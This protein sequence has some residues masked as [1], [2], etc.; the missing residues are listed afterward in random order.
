MLRNG[1][2]RDEEHLRDFNRKIVALGEKLG[3]PV[4]A[5][6]DVHFLH[7]EDSIY[8]TIVQAGQGYEDCE[9]QPPLYYK[10]TQEML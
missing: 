5:T 2:A 8:R 9:L 6:G 7:P 3:K 1:T 10:T 4:A